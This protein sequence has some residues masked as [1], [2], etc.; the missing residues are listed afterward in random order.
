MESAG[1]NFLGE[2]A[3]DGHR[4]RLDRV[5]ELPVI[6]PSTSPEPTV[7]L[8]QLD[9]GTHFHGINRVRQHA[10]LLSR[11]IGMG[12]DLQHGLRIGQ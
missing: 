9:G 11:R 6:A 10:I 2:F 3:G 5:M 7:G 12:H 1:R 4:S 8:D